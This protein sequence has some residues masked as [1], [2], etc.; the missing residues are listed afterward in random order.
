MSVSSDEDQS[1]S[2]EW[3]FYRDRPEWKDIEPIPQDDGEEP[4]V[5]IA[6]SPKCMFN[7]FI[8]ILYK[9]PH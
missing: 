3:V 8:L 7:H 9:P 2:Q 1:D 6:Y 4:I 5:S